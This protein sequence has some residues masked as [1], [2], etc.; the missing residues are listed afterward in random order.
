MA[1][2]RG[3]DANLAPMIPNEKFLPS[4][5]FSAGLRYPQRTRMNQASDR[6]ASESEIVSAAA[7][8]DESAFAEI[9]DRYYPEI[10]RFVTHQSYN[11]SLDAAEIAQVVFVKAAGAI[12]RMGDPG[13]VRA[14]LYK[15]AR[16]AITDARR[17]SASLERTKQTLVE[18]APAPVQLADASER[19][20]SVREWVSRL[21][22]PYR[23]AVTL[24]YFQG[25]NHREA[26]EIAGC[27][28]GT[29][30]WRVSQAVRQLREMMQ[31]ENQAP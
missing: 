19:N 7:R 2:S 10:F 24:V 8:G 16:N 21:D 25:L 18:M 9:F 17:K 27:A 4:Q 6:S 12:G 20:A 23:K 5:G 28:E 29:I 22:A 14:W 11:T 1:R 15:I 26:G 30:S 31:E 13:G 3:F